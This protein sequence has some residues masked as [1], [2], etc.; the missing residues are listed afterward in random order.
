MCYAYCLTLRST[1]QYKVRVPAI[2]HE[3]LV[4]AMDKAGVSPQ[5]LATEIDK[6]L[7][8]VCDIR[9]GRRTLK[10]N[11]DLRNR[12]AK[13]CDVPVHWIERRPEPD[14]VAS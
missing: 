13:A 7:Q 12:I 6:S 1:T 5:Q 8:Y 3:L 2:D 10:R 14:A 11:P 9:A 4:K